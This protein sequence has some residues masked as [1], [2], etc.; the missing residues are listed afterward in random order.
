MKLPKETTRYC[1]TCKKHTAQQVSIAKQKSR[2][3]AHPLSR[4]STS[5]VK[6]RGYRSGFGNLGRFSKPAVKSWKRKTKVTKRMNILYKCKTCGKAKGLHRS[7]RSSRI[8]IGEKVA[9]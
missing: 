9:K 7:I 5:R 8:E 1:P 2:S 6:A 4:W 3:S